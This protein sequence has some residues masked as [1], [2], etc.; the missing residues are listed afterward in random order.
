MKKS[1]FEKAAEIFVGKED[2]ETGLKLLRVSPLDESPSSPDSQNTLWQTPYHQVQCFTPDGNGICLNYVEWESGNGKPKKKYRSQAILDLTTGKTSYPFPENSYLAHLS[3]IFPLAILIRMENEIPLVCIYDYSQ[4]KELASFSKPGWNLQE[5]H[6]M[7]DGRNVVISYYLGKYY[8]ELCKSRFY[9]LTPEGKSEEILSMDGYFCNHVQ[10]CPTDAGLYSYNRWPSPKK[11]CEVV[12]HIRELYG[13][14]DIELPQKKGVVKPGPLWGGQRDHYLWTP[15]GSRIASYFSPIASDSKNHFD[16][17]WWLSVMDWRT[18]EDLASPYPPDR[19]SGHFAVSKDSRYLFMVGRK[20]FPYV[21]AV[22][23]EKLRNGWNERILCRCPE[24]LVRPDNVGP[25]HMP[26]CLPDQS[27]VIFTAA[28][29]KPEGGVYIV[30][31]P[32]D[33]HHKK[34]YKK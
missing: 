21:F 29:H 10:G 16:Y 34:E 3:N 8:D 20:T 9:L 5:A 13:T 23:I 26:F 4:K 19:W 1:I 2:P 24:S 22:E 28:W 31:L 14:F 33:M 30:E 18:G 32:H 11:P 15:D 27:G 12:H 7:A 6:F 17:G 25:F